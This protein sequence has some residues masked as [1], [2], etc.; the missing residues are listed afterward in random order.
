[1]TLVCGASGINFKKSMYCITLGIIVSYIRT[2]YQVAVKLCGLCGVST[3]A[4]AVLRA[5]IEFLMF[6]FT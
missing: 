2:G 3:V 5:K 1:M 6:V 4:C